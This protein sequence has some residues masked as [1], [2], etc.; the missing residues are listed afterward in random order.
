MRSEHPIAI[1]TDNAVE[2]MWK[3]SA[4]PWS[5]SEFPAKKKKIKVI[6]CQLQE[7]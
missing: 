4:S 7:I 3:P 5:E 6:Y 2:Y 1:V